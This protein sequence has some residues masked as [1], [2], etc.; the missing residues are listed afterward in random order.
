MIRY[1]IESRNRQFLNRTAEFKDVLIVDA[2]TMSMHLALFHAKHAV[3]IRV[4]AALWMPPGSDRSV[5]NSPCT[6]TW[7]LRC[8][9]PR[10]WEHVV[11]S[12]WDAY[13]RILILHLFCQDRQVTCYAWIHGGLEHT[14]AKIKSSV[15]PT[16]SFIWS[17]M[18]LWRSIYCASPEL[19]LHGSPAWYPA[20]WRLHHK[21]YPSERHI[22]KLKRNTTPVP[23]LCSL[24]HLHVLFCFPILSLSRSSKNLF[25]TW[26]PPVYGNVVLIRLTYITGVS[27]HIRPWDRH[28]SSSTSTFNSLSSPRCAPQSLGCAYPSLHRFPLLLI[29]SQNYSPFHFTPPYGK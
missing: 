4:S 20:T 21:N 19:T 27:A 17:F 26:R 13:S 2:A 29:P 9:F 5:F 14:V 24:R 8:D 18:K 1:S 23:S 11:G 10:F 7:A 28:T 12:R 16:R 25:R 6:N 3:V 15:S 22:Q